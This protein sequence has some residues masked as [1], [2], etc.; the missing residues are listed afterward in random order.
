MYR[1]AKSH[2]LLAVFSIVLLTTTAGAQYNPESFSAMKWRLVGPH[3]AGRVTAVAGISARPAIYYFG[4]PGGGVGRQRMAGS[5]GNQFST[6]RAS[7]QLAR[8]RW[9]L[10]TRM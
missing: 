10:R 3:R 4:T 6:A 9:R 8:W 1:S 2:F 7:R 5:F